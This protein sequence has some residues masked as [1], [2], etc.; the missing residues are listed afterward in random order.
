MGIPEPASSRLRKLLLLRACGLSSAVASI[1]RE[2]SAGE[3]TLLPHSRCLWSSA[4]VR[5]VWLARKTISSRAH[6][7]R[8]WA[9]GST[10][11]PTGK[12]GGRTYML[13]HH[14]GWESTR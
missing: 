9:P 8:S 2:L 14:L 10:M 12:T 1:D 7:W 5:Q 4:Q 11:G 13:Y 6:G 3:A